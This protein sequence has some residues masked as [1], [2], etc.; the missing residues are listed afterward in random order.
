MKKQTKEYRTEEQFCDIAD[1]CLNGNWRDAAA[2][3]VEF[4]FYANDLINFNK[5]LELFEDLYDIAEL[6]EM[7]QELRK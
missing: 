7:A 2:Q 4:G 1:N 3:C 5:Q 6:I